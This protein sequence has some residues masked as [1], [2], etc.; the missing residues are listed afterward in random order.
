MLY[1]L[2]NVFRRHRLEAELDAELSYH[3]DRLESEHR[4]RG[5]SPREARAAAIRDMGGVVQTKEAYRDQ[6]SVPVVE[7]F[8]RDIRFGLRTLRRTPTVSLAVVATL[9]IGIG[10]NTAM[11]TVVNGVLLKP[12]P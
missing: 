5:L 6:A 10:A 3:C 9:A 7:T 12:L 1:R 2:F 8:C 11:F 4:A